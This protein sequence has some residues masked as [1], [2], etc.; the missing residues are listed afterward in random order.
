MRIVHDL[1]R[2]IKEYDNNFYGGNGNAT[3]VKLFCC[4]KN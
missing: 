2:I 1:T 3:K 4:V